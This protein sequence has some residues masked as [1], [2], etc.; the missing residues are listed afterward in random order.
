MIKSHPD[1][2]IFNEIYPNMLKPQ[3]LVEKHAPATVFFKITEENYY[4]Y[5][6]SLD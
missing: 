4:R 5:C 2:S 3:E 1:R 6:F